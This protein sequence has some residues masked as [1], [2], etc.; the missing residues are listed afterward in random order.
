MPEVSVLIPVHDRPQQVV[1]AIASCL[2]Q[3]DVDLE[4]VVVDDGSTD[5]TPAAVT[6]IDDDRVRLIRQARRGVTA[7]RNRAARSARGTWLLPLDSDDTLVPDGVRA[8]LRVGA[9]DVDV[10]CGGTV[11]VHADGATSSRSPTRLGPEYHGVTALFF[12]GAMLIRATAWSEVG[13]QL[14]GLTFGENTELGLRLA[15]HAFVRGRRCAH[16][17]DPIVRYTVPPRPRYDHLARARASELALRTDWP[18][19]A[20]SR[21]ARAVGLSIWAV[22][23]ARSG[24]PAR[25]TAAQLQAVLTS[26]LAP[27]HVARLIVMA[28]PPL[29][30][31][32]YRRLVRDDGV[33]ED[34]SA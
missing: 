29:R 1:A 7:A 13:G 23:Y 30:R 22:Q 8:L 11:D 20:S 31:R 4:V 15:A 9:D 5:E 17:R 19:F 2:T 34:G 21:H 12:P 14:D 6:A 27:V 33:A 16:V 18:L 3:R 26:R 25:A 28:V 32:R 24:E 10:V